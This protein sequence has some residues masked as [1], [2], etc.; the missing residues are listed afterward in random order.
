[1]IRA[2][3][4]ATKTKLPMDRP[5]TTCLA[6]AAGL[7]T[8]VAVAVR[9]APP[10][11]LPPAPPA[12]VVYELSFEPTP[13]ASPALPRP[14]VT[15]APLRVPETAD[16]PRTAG[17]PQVAL[18]SRSSAGDA[19]SSSGEGPA[20]A[21][22]TDTSG[23]PNPRA[24]R[25]LELGLGGLWMRPAL[26]DRPRTQGWKSGA[27]TAGGL[28]AELEARDRERGLARGGL[29]A[30]HARSAAISLGP[31]E[32]TATFVVDTD[33]DGK[34]QAVTLS[35][36]RGGASWTRV[37]AALTRALATRRLRVPR[38]ARGL[39]VSIRVEAKVQLPSGSRPGDSVRAKGPGA[40]FDVADIGARASRVVSARVLNETLL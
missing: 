12:P 15:A 25:P 5:L 26:P 34:V 36:A 33:A 39:R 38:G 22:T 37:R 35:E 9:S 19:G 4:G 11:P 13:E 6:L 31:A 21:Q 29:I 7:H 8:L 27:E 40:E 18:S 17:S 20:V 23:E 3:A 2:V 14:T 1:M 30:T 32:G 24:A 16:V 10:G 28:G